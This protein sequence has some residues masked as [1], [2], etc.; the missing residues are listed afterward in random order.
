MGRKELVYGY[1]TIERNIVGLS[2]RQ[3]E[4]VLGLRIGRMALGARVLLLLT[5]PARGQF[6]Y[7]AS[8][9]R[10]KAERLVSAAQRSDFPIP[11]A[12]LGQRLVKVVPNIPHSSDEKYPAAASPV[13]QWELVGAVAATEICTLQVDQS[14]WPP[15]Q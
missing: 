12:W 10:P 2:P 1:F 6:L 3:M 4:P 14:Y 7:A 8:T 11:H 5:Q 9:K 15:R 13:E